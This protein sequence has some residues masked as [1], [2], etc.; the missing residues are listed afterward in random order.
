VTGA[1]VV[2]LI[3]AVDVDVT[4]RLRGA[5]E[6]LLS[7]SRRPVVVDLLRARGGELAIVIA[8]R[9][10]T[11]CSRPPMPP[12]RVRRRSNGRSENDPAKNNGI[13]LRL[14]VDPTAVQ[15]WTSIDHTEIAA[16]PT[17]N[18]ALEPHG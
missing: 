9:G 6:S 4:R 12:D 17:L 3:G 13:G 16:Y 7:S 10:I 5:V 2:T 8:L 1:R 11:S 15:A 14:V 18:A